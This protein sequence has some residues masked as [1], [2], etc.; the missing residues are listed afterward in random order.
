MGLPDGRGNRCPNGVGTVTLSQ[1]A[2]PGWVLLYGRDCA[3]RLQVLAATVGDD[4]VHHL[5]DAKL[6]VRPYCGLYV[7]KVLEEEP[8]RR[9]VRHLLDEL[10]RGL[11]IPLV[12][13]AA[14]YAMGRK[15]PAGVQLA[16]GALV[17]VLGRPASPPAS[18]VRRAL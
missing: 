14:Y 9:I 4:A 2:R 13:V 15:V 3:E 6:R 18:R 7:R 5:L 16:D 8:G 10:L 12:S 11:P 1:T 17:N